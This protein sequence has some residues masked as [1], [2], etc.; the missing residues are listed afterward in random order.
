MSAFTVQFDNQPGKLAQLCQAMAGHGVN[1]ILCAV[2]HGGSGTVALVADDERAARGV[3]ETAG[4]DYAER[5]SLTVRLE[6]VPGAGAAT[7]GKL[8]DAG[9]NVELVLPI[10]V[11]AE[12]FFAVIC[13][14]D[15]AAAE[16]ALADQLVAG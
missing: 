12:E 5:P 4:M 13:V 3:L 7:F 15:V 8:S 16:T 2:G 10:R 14:D 1:L 9:V 11:S 6:N